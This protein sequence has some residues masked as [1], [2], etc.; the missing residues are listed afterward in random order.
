MDR[1]LPKPRL[2][3]SVL[4]AAAVAA[5]LLALILIAQPFHAGRTV[6]MRAVAVSVGTV[7]RGVFRDFVPL[8]GR[9]VPR[10][11]VF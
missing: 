10:D 4:V 7:E 1:P 3:R 11:I 9:I 2:R 6:R 8:R 5:V